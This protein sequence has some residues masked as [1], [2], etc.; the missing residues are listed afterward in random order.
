MGSE[1][2]S[3]PKQLKSAEKVEIPSTAIRESLPKQRKSAEKVEIPRAAD[4]KI[5]TQTVENPTCPNIKNYT[6]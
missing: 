6:N 2:K 4:R 1:T 5:S 3:L